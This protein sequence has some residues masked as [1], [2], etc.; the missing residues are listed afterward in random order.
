[1]FVALEFDHGLFKP[2]IRWIV[3]EC[4]GLGRK[5][6]GP[7]ALSPR[8]DRAYF[9]SPETARQDAEEYAAFKQHQADNCL[10]AVETQLLRT[11]Q[12]GESPGRHF[13][14]PW[15]HLLMAARPLSWAV[16]EWSGDE[17]LGG[18]RTDI[19]YFAETSEAEPDAKVF[20]LLRERRLAAVPTALP[21]SSEWAG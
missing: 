4:A 5:C 18:P 19:A 6:G 17:D 20:A 11:A 3:V 12:Y 8:Q 14:Y 7:I 10:S 2:Q 21:S 15:D 16:L 9:V 1:M 13:A